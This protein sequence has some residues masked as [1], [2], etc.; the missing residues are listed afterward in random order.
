MKTF[1]DFLAAARIEYAASVEKFN[2]EARLPI[3][4]QLRIGTMAGPLVCS[5]S[6]D[7]SATFAPILDEPFDWGKIKPDGNVHPISPDAI[8][9]SKVNLAYGSLTPEEAP[10][11]F[12]RSKYSKT[13]LNFQAD[14]TTV[15]KEAFFDGLLSTID[16]L[17]EIPESTTWPSEVGVS[18]AGNPEGG[19]AEE[20]AFAA[21]L[22]DSNP[23]I[24]VKGPPGTGK[25]DLLAKVALKLASQ[26]Q[27]VGIVSGSH[28]AVNNALRRIAEMKEPSDTFEI[29][30][31]SDKDE[32]I[33]GVIVR[34]MERHQQTPE[35]WGAVTASAI[36]MTKFRKENGNFLPVVEFAF[37]TCD[38]LLLDEAGQIPAFEAAALSF[39]A[40]RMMLFG[41]EDQ[42]PCIC[43]GQH[44]PGSY[45]DSSA[46]A[47][48]RDMLPDCSYALEVSHR[49]NS[50]ICGL[51]Q[52]HF[53]PDIPGLQSGK[54]ADAHLLE[55][56]KPLSSLIK[57]DFP[58]K[59]PR[60]SRCKEEAERVVAWVQRLLTM[61]VTMDE[62]SGMTT[63]NLT[64]A[65][66]AILTPF[67]SQVRAIQSALSAP[68][69]D[70]EEIR[71]GSVEKMQGQGA[72]VVIYSLAS[73]SKDYIA[74][75]TEWL[76]S[77]NRWNVAISRAIA[78]AIIVGDIQAHL[79]ATPTTLDG[80][81]AQQKIRRITDNAKHFLLDCLKTY[82]K[83]RMLVEE[84]DI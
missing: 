29:R 53:Y 70:T 1:A 38:V 40:P 21:C 55:D 19:S 15:F 48:I 52:R 2:T 37:G 57:D 61:Q 81:A 56:G 24:A 11:T 16:V 14:T 65:D 45:G 63:R 6:D 83:P 42:L 68:G 50:T 5:T 46:M 60:L 80:I 49:M 34:K 26:H 22:D 18:N 84:N 71:I 79:S 41:D 25:T 72:A 73:S 74:G 7:K 76:L 23:I 4:E 17:K 51:I 35:I 36:R 27:V 10:T 54:N 20:I 31:H 62:G 13:A 39:I 28:E 43:H 75:Q 3:D 64:P 12:E 33:E 44:P 67:R 9:T 58:H 82:Q 32:E 78:C 77:A 69:V 30:K 66:I 8:L 47:Y 59:H